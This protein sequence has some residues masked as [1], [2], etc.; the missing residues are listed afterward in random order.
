LSERPWYRRYPSDFIA[1]TLRM[2]LEEK[3]AYSVVLD[4]IYDRGGAI[5]DDARYI[6]GVCGCSV[7]K[8]NAI[9]QRLINMGKLLVGD[10]VISNFRAEKELEILAEISRERAESGRK[11]GEKNA[12]TKDVSSKNNDLGQ[13]E[14]KLARASPLPIPFK[15]ERQADLEGKKDEPELVRVDRVHDWEL[16]EAC[17]AVTGVKLADYLKA[18]FYPPDIIG[19]ARAHMLAQST[20]ES[21]GAAS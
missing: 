4:L 16:F 9:R 12:E 3:G 6:A 13:A 8:W 14:L 10:G 2:S 5:P 15:K 1:G 7:R 19:Q 21:E 11:G 20:I 18:G 17:Q